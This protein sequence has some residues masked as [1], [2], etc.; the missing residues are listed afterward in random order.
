MLELTKPK[1]VGTPKRSERMTELGLSYVVH[2]PRLH[3]GEVWNEQAHDELLALGGENQIPFP[4]DHRNEK[5]L[6]EGDD[7]VDYLA[8]QYG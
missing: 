5:T 3:G 2:N 8:E 7:I 4:V 1:D 6:Y